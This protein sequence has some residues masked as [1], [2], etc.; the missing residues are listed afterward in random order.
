MVCSSH[1]EGVKGIVSPI[2]GFSLSYTCKKTEIKHMLGA[3]GRAGKVQQ[4]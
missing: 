4:D 1:A 3:L 2:L